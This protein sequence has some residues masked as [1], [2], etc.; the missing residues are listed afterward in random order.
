M[1][2]VLSSKLKI[3]TSAVFLFILFLYHCPDTKEMDPQSPESPPSNSPFIMSLEPTLLI[4]ADTQLENSL[5]KSGSTLGLRGS[6]LLQPSP[7]PSPS[8]RPQLISLTQILI[9]YVFLLLKNILF[10]AGQSSNS[11]VYFQSY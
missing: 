3:T 6:P 5:P 4:T 11:L 1:V 2:F 9:P 7:Y 8:P 10:C